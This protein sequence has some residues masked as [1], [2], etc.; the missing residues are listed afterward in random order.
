MVHQGARFMSLFLSYFFNVGGDSGGVSWLFGVAVFGFSIW[1]AIDCWQ[2]GRDTWWI[3]IILVFQP[4]GALIY[5]VTQYWDSTRLEHGLWQRL[6]IG[7]RIRDVKSRAHYLDTSTGFE[8]LGD[9]Y[10]SVR[11]WAQAEEGYRAAL[12]RDAGN[13]DAQVRLG[14]VLVELGRADEAWS[15]LGP[16]YQKNPGFDDDKLI[17]HLARCQAMRGN[18]V[19]A[20]N[21]YE[22][23]LRRH[24]YTEV[25]LE[26]AKVLLQAGDR[27]A[28]RKALEELIR[29]AQHAPKFAQRRDRRW[30]REARR[31]ERTLA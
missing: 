2:R 4:I 15:L 3:W 23:F 13:L 17:R 31:L 22:Y 7:S 10:A 16:A 20:R 14:Y 29:D 6:T 18:F 27:E 25:Q 26:Y 30:I 12:Q 19:D 8:E 1:M 28:G 24:T 11:K 21:L 5:F 9:L